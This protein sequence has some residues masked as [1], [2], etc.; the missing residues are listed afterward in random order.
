MC[1][2][3]GV[4]VCVTLYLLM[5][6]RNQVVVQRVVS[7]TAEGWHLQLLFDDY[8]RHL[9]DGLYVYE[10]HHHISALFSVRNVLL[11]AQIPT[12]SQ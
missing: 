4:F 7:I 5:R 6:R 10:A 3:V 1:V 8:F 11:D 9:Y 12:I 2:G